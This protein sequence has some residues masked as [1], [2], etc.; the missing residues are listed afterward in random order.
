MARKSVRLAIRL[1]PGYNIEPSERLYC[2]RYFNR[3]FGTI[4]WI[5]KDRLR[6]SLRESF[7]EHVV[8]R[9]KIVCILKYRTF[10][11]SIDKYLSFVDLSTHL[12]LYSFF[13][14]L[15][16]MQFRFADNDSFN[17]ICTEEIWFMGKKMTN[18]VSFVNTCKYINMM[19]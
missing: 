15:F 14:L 7:R 5:I 10:N 18:S 12:N 2:S 19:G 13:P 1:N 6:K 17:S 3:F 16:C 9:T 4:F 8:Q 11:P